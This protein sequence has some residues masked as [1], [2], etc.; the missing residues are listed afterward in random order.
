MRN[1]ESLRNLA[2][3]LNER[4][5]TL[6]V[7]G[8]AMPGDVVASARPDAHGARDRHHGRRTGGQSS[9]ARSGVCRDGR[10]GRPAR[11]PR[12]R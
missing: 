1:P 4:G 11:A 6:E 2:R 12:R 5:Y 8:V 7:R 9:A 3:R 10:D